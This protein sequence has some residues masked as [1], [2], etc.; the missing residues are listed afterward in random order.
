V[1]RK[2]ILAEATLFCLPGLHGAFRDAV[3]DLRKDAADFQLFWLDATPEQ[4]VESIHRRARDEK[5][6]DCAEARARLGYFN[7]KMAGR[8]A[9]RLADAD[10]GGGAIKRYLG[11]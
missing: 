9:V 7:G 8:H 3:L 11:G 5:K 1:S 10:A 6:I 2:P 4:L